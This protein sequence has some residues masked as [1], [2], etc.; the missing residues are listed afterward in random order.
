MSPNQTATNP[1]SHQLALFI[2]LLIA[3]YSLGCSCGNADRAPKKTGKSSQE[4]QTPSIPEVRIKEL[5]YDPATPSIICK[6]HNNE[7]KPIEP[8]KCKLKITRPMGSQVTIQGTTFTTKEEAYLAIAD[9]IPA[10]HDLSKAYIIGLGVDKNPTLTFQLMYVGDSGE[11]AIG[12][13]MDITCAVDIQLELKDIQYSLATGML[14]CAVFNKGKTSIQD[15]TVHW[16]CITDYVRILDDKSARI[17]KVG[18]GG[19]NAAAE[20]VNQQLGELRY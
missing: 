16:R 12:D 6:L 17:E 15:I 11:Q 18:I 1:G 8:G 19:L 2:G 4:E 9:Q 14:S 3:C 13:P 10:N 20:A 5:T 7:N